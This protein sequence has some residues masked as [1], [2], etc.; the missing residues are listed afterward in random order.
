MFKL[1]QVLL[2]LQLNE[3]LVELWKVLLLMQLG[4]HMVQ[5]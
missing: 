1:W 3:H 2:L 4:E 5:L